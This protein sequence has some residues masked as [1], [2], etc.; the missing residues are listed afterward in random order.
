MWSNF[1]THAHYCDGNGSMT[2]YLEA[3]R[4]EG[5]RHIGFSS[6]APLPFPCKWSMD[7]EALPAYLEEIRTA[8]QSFPDVEVYSGLE[9]DYIPRVISPSDFRNQ[10]DYTVGSIHFVRGLRD[11]H[12][13]IDNTQDVFDE[14]LAAIFDNNIQEAL[15]AYFALTREMLEVAPPDILGH[16]DKIKINSLGTYFSEDEQWYRSEVEKTLRTIANTKTTVEVNTRGLYKKKSETTYPSPWILERLLDLQVPVTICSDSH[17]PREL[18]REFAAT[19]ELLVNI[20]FREVS[21]L[22]N[23]QWTSVPLAEYGVFS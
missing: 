21:V 15:T 2:E 17:H 23:R 19:R 16:L 5:V 18:T 13:E 7:A 8:R 11:R 1:H 3:C 4:S 14:G 20:G 12:W 6:H 22:I 9:V 10:L